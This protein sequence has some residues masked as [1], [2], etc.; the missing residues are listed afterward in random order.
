MEERVVGK[1]PV[2]RARLAQPPATI[3]DDSTPNWDNVS[4]AVLHP[5]NIHQPLRL[6]LLRYDR[7]PDS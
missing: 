5:S 3:A 2:L 4:A 7:N 6:Q 1:R